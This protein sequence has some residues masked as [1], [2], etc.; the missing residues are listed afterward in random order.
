MLLI[1]SWTPSWADQGEIKKANVVAGQKAPFDGVL[2]SRAALAKIIND[3]EAKLKEAELA[4]E[5]QKRDAAAAASQA[6]ALCQVK[7]DGVKQEI[8][9]LDSGCQQ[10][11]SILENALKECEARQSSFFKNPYFNFVAGALVS[12]GVCALT[13]YG[14]R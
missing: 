14:T 13:V 6:E 9:I 2:L 5:K 10:Q 8:G 1:A 7:L 4:L 12:G 11:V 3:Y